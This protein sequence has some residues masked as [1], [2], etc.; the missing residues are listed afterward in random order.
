MADAVARL[1]EAVMNYEMETIA[2]LAKQ[3]LKDGV[4]PL[5]AIEKGLAEG[6]KTVGEKFG[7]GEIFLPELVMGA[8]AMKAALAVLE[9]AVPKGK[10]RSTAGKVL[11]GT[12]QDDIHEIGKNLVSTMLASNGF[13]V[14][15]LGVNVSGSDF[16]KKADE[17]KANIVAMSALMTTT[18]PRMAE[19]I[20]PLKKKSKAVKVMV[21]GAPVTDTYAKEIGADGYSGDA[22]SAVEVAKRLVR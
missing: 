18:M 8:E 19:V 13:E 1:K 12:V 17:Q 11:I 14:V 2:D 3:A 15:D 5:V 21:G 9:P 4:D 10:H 16:L 7:R 20:T 6:I 22:S